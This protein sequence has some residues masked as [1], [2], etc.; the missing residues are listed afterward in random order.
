MS[1]GKRLK[2]K[3]VEKVNLWKIFV[4]RQGFEEKNN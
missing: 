1:V 2:K 4:V 3:T